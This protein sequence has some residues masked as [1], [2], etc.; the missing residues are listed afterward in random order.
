MSV[1]TLYSPTVVA[2]LTLRKKIKIN[3]VGA[4]HYSTVIVTTFNLTFS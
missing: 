3:S 1:M 2:L 4:L